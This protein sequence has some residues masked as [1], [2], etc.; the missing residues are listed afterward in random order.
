M[1]P[2]LC[3]AVDSNHL[4]VREALAMV[5][6]EG[7]HSGCTQLVV[8]MHRHSMGSLSGK[9]RGE[10]YPMEM[11]WEETGEGDLVKGTDPRVVGLGTE[12]WKPGFLGP[13][14][15]EVHAPGSVVSYYRSSSYYFLRPTMSPQ[16]NTREK[17]GS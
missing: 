11:I 3:S 13:M 2:P 5:E 17:K 10:H 15:R 4:K 8:A 14:G 7:C 1:G 12:P 16:E 6:T 9:G